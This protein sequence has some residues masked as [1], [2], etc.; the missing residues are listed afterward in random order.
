[1]ARICFLYPCLFN[2]P[3]WV[4]KKETG[5]LSLSIPN[6]PCITFFMMVQLYQNLSNQVWRNVNRR[7]KGDSWRPMWTRT[8]CA[9]SPVGCG[10]DVA[11]PMNHIPH[12][13]FPPSILF[14][15]A[16]VTGCKKRSQSPHSRPASLA[17]CRINKQQNKTKTLTS[18]IKSALW[19]G[20]CPQSHI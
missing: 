15:R 8:V 14:W 3:T 19:D 5:M 18:F 17:E 20:H 16:P 12:W 4:G 10:V 13:L 7:K 1:M 11:P 9:W 2:S 6:P